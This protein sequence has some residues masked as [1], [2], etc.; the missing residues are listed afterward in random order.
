MKIAH[1]A[2]H[3]YCD[4]IPLPFA[5]L[6]HILPKYSQFELGGVEGH[7]VDLRVA[8][9][10]AQFSPSLREAL[11]IGIAEL[12]SGQGVVTSPNEL[13]SEIHSELAMSHKG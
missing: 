2:S 9:K 1:I 4:S 13:L 10:A 5:C 12:D 8:R 11:D 3:S 7:R 6:L